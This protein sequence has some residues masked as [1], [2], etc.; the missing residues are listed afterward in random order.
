[1]TTTV[2]SPAP[3]LPAAYT[4][5]RTLAGENR[6]VQVEC[7]D[8][9]CSF[10]ASP[11]CGNRCFASS[12]SNP[13]DVELR[14]CGEKGY[15]AFAAKD[16][17][18]NTF[19]VEY[20]GDV[21]DKA[22]VARRKK[23]YQ[24]SGNPHFY[25]M[26]VG[27]NVTID[28][29]MAGGLARFLNHSCDPNC[30]TQ[31]WQVG[32]ETRVAMFSTRDI[33]AGEE[34]SYDYQWSHFGE[35]PWKCLCGAATCRGFLADA[36]AARKHRAHLR[37]RRNGIGL[38]DVAAALD[39]GYTGAVSSEYTYMPFSQGG[40]A[41]VPVHGA[42]S[43]LPPDDDRV[44]FHRDHR[45]ACRASEALWGSAVSVLQRPPKDHTALEFVRSHHL[46]SCA[47]R[48][49]ASCSLLGAA[50]SARATPPAATAPPPP[51]AAT[52]P[53][54]PVCCGLEQHASEGSTKAWCR[55]WTTP[56]EVLCRMK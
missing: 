54:A 7:T 35:A 14:Y 41:W 31:K 52:P 18:A 16:I 27:P 21:I 11:L 32:Q 1:V 51:Q 46:Q 24:E 9:N 45:A 23:L 28:A 30:M 12:S 22:E 40:G 50:A 2:S 26:E 4:R 6:L 34:L 25:L 3:P 37:A 15:G 39:S 53:D 48:W 17:P 44:L 10:G 13:W 38:D 19:V 56:C 20:V 43:A 29:G 49:T 8:K 36:G 5:P 55:V 42:K 33:T 47:L